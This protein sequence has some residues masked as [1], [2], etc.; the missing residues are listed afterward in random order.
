MDLK[1]LGERPFD[2][3]IPNLMWLDGTLFLRE[4]NGGES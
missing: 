2:T 3:E 1:L 4:H